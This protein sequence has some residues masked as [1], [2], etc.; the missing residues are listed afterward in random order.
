MS[1]NKKFT[2][3]AVEISTETLSEKYLS[4]EPFEINMK[5][6]SDFGIRHRVVL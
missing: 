1:Q 3:K 5:C 4:E 2:I 6:T